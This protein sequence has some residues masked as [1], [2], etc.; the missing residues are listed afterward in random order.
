MNQ[1]HIPFDIDQTPP[2]DG[3]RNAAQQKNEGKPLAVA[4]RSEWAARLRERFSCGG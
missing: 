2:T 3:Q 4:E 1:A